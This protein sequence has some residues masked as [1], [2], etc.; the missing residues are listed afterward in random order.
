MRS[1]GSNCRGE[2]SWESKQ[3]IRTKQRRKVKEDDH[4]TEDND[5]E[6]EGEEKE[7]EVEPEEEKEEVEEA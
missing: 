5:K 6:A 4:Q 2:R 1:G 3:C 7:R